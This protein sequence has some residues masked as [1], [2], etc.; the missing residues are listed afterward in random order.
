MG[1]LWRNLILSFSTLFLKMNG[2]L[3]EISLRDMYRVGLTLVLQEWHLS[4][5]P[6]SNSKITYYVRRSLVKNFNTVIFCLLIFLRVD[7]CKIPVQLRI[8]RFCVFSVLALHMN[9]WKKNYEEIKI[10]AIK[11]VQQCTEKSMV[12]INIFTGT[13][14]WVLWN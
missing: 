5:S 6:K 1:P 10:F 11:S 4:H 12:V 14:L 8:W 9:V 3:S 7:S 13:S 2:L